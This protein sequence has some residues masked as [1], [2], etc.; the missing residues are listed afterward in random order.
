MRH[1]KTLTTVL[2][3]KSEAFTEKKTADQD[4]AVVTL[5]SLQ[6]GPGSRFLADWTLEIN[7]LFI[8]WLFALFCM[9]Q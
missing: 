6:Q 5:L 1:Y 7:K 8:I 3:T 2:S 4:I 9:L